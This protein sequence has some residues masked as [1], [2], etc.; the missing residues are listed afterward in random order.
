MALPR[1]IIKR[2]EERLRAKATEFLAKT[3]LIEELT[4]T[5]RCLGLEVHE[6]K[7]E[8]S[9]LVAKMKNL[10]TLLD[11]ALPL[12]KIGHLQLALRDAAEDVDTGQTRLSGELRFIL[13]YGDHAVEDLRA[14]RYRKLEVFKRADDTAL[15]RGDATA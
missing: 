3:K 8:L 9:D 5:A 13:A 15:K 10:A 6:E 2:Y 14:S 7:K 12:D 4:E 1:I 11:E